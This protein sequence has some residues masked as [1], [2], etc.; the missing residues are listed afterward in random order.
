MKTKLIRITTAPISLNILLKGQHK[1]MCDKG[2]E[3]VG[4]SSD[5]QYLKEVAENEK[6][7]IV[8]INM[9]RIISP[10]RDIRSLFAF[11]LLCRREK[12]HIVHSHT[13]KAGIVGMLGA[14]LARV[15]I[16]LH[17]VAGL[18]LMEAKG[19]RRIV[20][21]LVEKFT[22][23]C[24]TFVY[25]NSRGLYDY[26]LTNRYISENRL[27]VLGNGSSNGI[28][29]NF[30]D[31]DKYS[32]LNRNKLR[33]ILGISHEDF[34]YIY[35]GRLVG[36]KGINELVAAFMLMIG[37]EA[38]NKK[39]KLL[40]VGDFESQLDPLKSV[41]VQAINDNTKILHVGF[42]ADV[43]PFLAISDCLVLPSYREGFPNVVLQAGSMC[44][45]SIVTNING[46]NEIIFDRQNGLIIPTKEINALFDAMVLVVSDKLLY[47]KLSNNSRRMIQ[48]RFEQKFFWQELFNEYAGLLS[49]IGHKLT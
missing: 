30:F 32:T 1:Y 36:D 33:N 5:G 49:K 24:S 44:L 45:P 19:F 10:L 16:R 8:A 11:Y 2:F 15:P 31:P 26:L 27:K 43:R 17:T 47:S 9:T 29:S 46:C 37:S 12:P 40:L 48:N 18:P 25:P 34:V 23:S 35:I 6:I 39:V 14:K 4:V 22:Y 20:L 38:T 21:E 41:T 7:K 13:P 3:V 42:Q 28:D